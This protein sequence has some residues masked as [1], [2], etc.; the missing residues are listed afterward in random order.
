MLWNSLRERG[1]DIEGEREKKRERGKERDKERER[2]QC[3]LVK[4][5]KVMRK[6]WDFPLALQDMQDFDKW[7]E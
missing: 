6:T 2:D 7:N 3:Q 1:E 4:F 5:K